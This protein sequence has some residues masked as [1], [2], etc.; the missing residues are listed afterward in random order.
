MAS[1]VRTKKKEYFLIYD[2]CYLLATV[3][4]WS[5]SSDARPTLEE[6]ID[7]IMH[8]GSPVTTREIK[9]TISFNSIISVFYVACC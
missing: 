2:P 3:E 8:Y 7:P 1:F 6:A 9:K 5:M 4:L